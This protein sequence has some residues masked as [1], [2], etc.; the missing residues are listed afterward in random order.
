VD[1]RE[2]SEVTQRPI[3]CSTNIP[4]GLLEM[5]ITELTQDLSTPICVHCASGDRAALAAE[6]LSS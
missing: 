1:V 3:N 6:Q 2:P 4:R 5:K